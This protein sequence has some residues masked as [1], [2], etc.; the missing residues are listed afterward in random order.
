M[1]MHMRTTN[2]AWNKGS[3]MLCIIISSMSNTSCVIKHIVQ[4]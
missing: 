3:D 4:P 2:A 1:M